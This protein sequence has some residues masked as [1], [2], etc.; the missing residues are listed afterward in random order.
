MFILA[1]YCACSGG[2]KSVGPGSGTVASIAVGGATTTV[3]IGSTITLTAGAFDASSAPVSGQ[4]FT[5]A[6]SDPLVA[7]VSQSGVV[8]GVSVGVVSI[9]ASIGSISGKTTVSVSATSAQQSCT[10]VTPLSM[11]VGD[12]HIVSGVE[13]SALC[14][15]GGAGTEYALVAFNSSLDTSGTQK[16][17]GLNST[18]TAATQNAPNPTL[19]PAHTASIS[20]AVPRDIGFEMRLREMERRDLN[21]K[22]AAARAWYASRTG[23]VARPPGFSAITGVSPS[24]SVGDKISLNG[25]AQSSCGSPQPHGA[26]I[27]AVST[28]AIVAVDTLTPPNGFTTTD[29]QN[30]AATFDTLIYPLDTLNYGAPTD[31]DGNGRV[32]LFFSPLVN[33]LSSNNSSSYVGGFFFSRDLFPLTATSTLAACAGS[34]VG[35]MFYLPIVDAAQIYN[36]FFKSKDTVTSQVNTTVVHEFQHL[37]NAGRHLYVNLAATRL[38]ESWLD[39]S[40]AMLAQELLYFRVSG[41]APKQKLTWPVISTG[42]NANGSQLGIVN[43]YLVQGLGA[44]NFYLQVPESST[45]YNNT[46][47]LATLGSGWEFLRYLLDQ[48]AGS[49]P[50]FTRAI[51]NGTVTGF[52]NLEN[53]FALTPSTLSNTYTSWSIAQYVDGTGISTNPVYSN[54]SWNFRSVLPNALGLS[55]FPLGIRTLTQNTPIALVLRGGSAAYIRFRVNA[56]LTGQIT[57]T[58]GIV[59]STSVVYALVRTF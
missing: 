23:A 20:R 59:A 22:F 11:N 25:N 53:V 58:N 12:V 43:A 2:D 19:T 28:H 42:A 17:V 18:N 35:E 7:T 44:L 34:N 57:P 52:A 39:E 47:N 21:P 27:V 14:I 37:I 1:L 9:S 5:W 15:S 4:T 51:D 46:E 32:L 29:Y 8:T 40:Q 55:G 49:Q 41:F 36:R 33:A 6:S 3:T 56:G 10:G 31:I 38:E 45:P 24:P 50:A 13:R 48:T 16:A 54:P 30:F 26:T